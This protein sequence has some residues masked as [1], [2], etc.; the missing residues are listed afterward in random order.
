VTHKKIEF[1]ICSEDI[2]KDVR[3]DVRYGRCMEDAHKLMYFNIQNW[4]FLRD[5]IVPLRG[6]DLNAPITIWL[7]DDIIV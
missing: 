5:A 3:K 6:T 4:G 2:R 7:P 1:G